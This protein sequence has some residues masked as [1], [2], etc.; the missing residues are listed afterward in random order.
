[1]TPTPILR[2]MNIDNRCFW[3]SVTATLLSATGGL[4]KRGSDE[5]SRLACRAGLGAED[6]REYVQIDPESE[7]KSCVF[8]SDL[9]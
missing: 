6:R 2:L 1:M 5:Y 7:G 4:L 3:I 8:L 9:V